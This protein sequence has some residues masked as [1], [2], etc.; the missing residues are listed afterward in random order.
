MK[1]LI[2]T[3]NPQ[4]RPF[5]KLLLRRMLCPLTGLCQAIGFVT[6]SPCEPRIAVAGGDMTGV[7]VLRGI[8]PPRPGVHHI[9]GSGTTYEEAIIRTLGETLERYAQHMS[10]VSGRHEIV[11]ASYRK[12]ISNGRRVLVPEELQYFS[13][14]QLARP[15]FPF[16]RL[17]P[18]AE[19]GWVSEGDENPFPA[20][21]QARIRD[22]VAELGV[23]HREARIA[24]MRAA[25]GVGTARCRIGRE[26]SACAS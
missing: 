25:I 20:H 23:E 4:L 16:S 7:H 6:R 5:T 17:D 18:D 26:I 1:V 13:K 14:S 8:P 22:T 11:F 24:Q 15:G 12:M 21:L 10:L 2:G 9:G 19:I 3:S